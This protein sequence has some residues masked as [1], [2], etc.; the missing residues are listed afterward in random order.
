MLLQDGRSFRVHDGVGDVFPSRFKRTPAAIECH[1]TMSLSD[2]S[3]KTMTITADTASERAYLPKV[4]TLNNKL[5]LADAGYVDFDYFD[6]I[7]QHG[8][9][10]LV[11]GT[12]SLNLII[13]EARNSNG[14]LLPKL[15]GKKLK[16]ICRKTNRSSALD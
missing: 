10:F 6:R 9:S 12:K 1:M 11:R 7:H 2:L 3:P 13:I 16:E 14:R 5:L 8:G 4:E 15:V